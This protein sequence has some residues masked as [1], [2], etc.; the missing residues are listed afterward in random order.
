MGPDVPQSA[1][2]A[3]A[4]VRIHRPKLLAFSIIFGTIAAAAIGMGFWWHS[5]HSPAGGVVAIDE[6]RPED[7][8]DAMET[9]V[10][11]PGYVGMEACAKC[12]ADRVAEF[13]GTNHERTFR[14]PKPRDMPRGFLPGQGNY[15]T[16]EPGL[17]FEMTREGDDFFLT[18]IHKKPGSEERMK[19]R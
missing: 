14:E 15:V 18:A 19:S 5:N 11:N 10:D 3:P 9:S 4:P 7:S 16:G 2:T 6:G 13:R 8:M 17:R 1:Q 12:H